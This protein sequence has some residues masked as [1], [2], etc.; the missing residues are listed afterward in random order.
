MQERSSGPPPQ[1][2]HDHIM[3]WHETERKKYEEERFDG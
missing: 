3:L 1:K 2:N